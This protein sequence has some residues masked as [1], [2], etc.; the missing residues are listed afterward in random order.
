MIDRA[1]ENVIRSSHSEQF[2]WMEKRFSISLRNSLPVWPKFVEVC[3]R[4][5][6]LT[7]TGG[8]VSQQYIDNC[9]HHKCDVPADIALGDTLPVDRKYFAEA[10]N[11]IYEIGVK[12]CH[13]MWRKF[14]PEEREAAD[15]KLNELGYNLIFG[16]AYGLAEALL[17]FGTDVLKTH[18][19][20]EIRRTMAINLANAVRLQGRRDEANKFL[21]KEDW[22]ACSDLFKVC[23]AAVKEDVTTVVRFMRLIGAGARSNIED[24]RTWPVFRVVR[25]QEPFIAAFEEIFGE[26]IIITTRAEGIA[27]EEEENEAP[28]KH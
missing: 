1:I 22:S 7:H 8:V 27:L 14:A 5:N 9:K 24:Y 12:L 6:L 4:R 19:S 16:R 3:E 11:A 15:S 10:V 28:T 13:V 17:L 23:V 20:D 21:D 25:T 18:A 2:D 26:S